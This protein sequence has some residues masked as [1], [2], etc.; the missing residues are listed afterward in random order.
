MLEAPPRL[1]F[2]LSCLKIIA[3]VNGGSKIH[4]IV[5]SLAVLG[6][7]GVVWRLLICLPTKTEELG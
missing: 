5:S 4:I 6:C 2:Q 1:E 3:I 7:K